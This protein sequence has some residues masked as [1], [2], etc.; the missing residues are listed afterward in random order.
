M[1]QKEIQ[2][3]VGQAYDMLHALKEQDAKGGQDKE[4]EKENEKEHDEK[5]ND[6]VDSDVGGPAAH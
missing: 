3:A 2:D 5:Q 1:R 4:K 6:A